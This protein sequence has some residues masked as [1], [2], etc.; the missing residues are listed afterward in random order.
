MADSDR[1]GHAWPLVHVGYHKTGTTWLQRHLF[2]V[3]DRGF[4]CPRRVQIYQA[5]VLP[6]PLDFDAAT[7]RGTFAPLL[8]EAKLRG[9]VPVLSHERLGGHFETG[10]YDSKEIAE[11]VAAVFEEA[12]VLI[13]IR[14]QES[15]ILSAYKQHLKRDGCLSLRTFVTSTGV[16]YGPRF[17]LT[18]YEYDRLIRC[19]QRLFGKDRVLVLPFE[20][21]KTK[22]EHFASRLSDFCGVQMA[23]GL[24]FEQRVNVTPSGA[25]LAAKRY[26]NWLFVAGPRNRSFTFALPK[27]LR[28]FGKISFFEK[29]CSNRRKRRWDEKSGAFVANHVGDHYCESN[30]RTADLTGLDLAGYGYKM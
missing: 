5:L 30:R 4:L 27:V 6:N 22:P 18:Q 12:R 3:P 20:Q 7:A 24:P 16:Y 8:E 1:R 2:K 9:L 13:C 14:E 23:E 28:R 17:S 11:R 26:F 21:F 15:M 10:G 19:Y 29:L 25:A